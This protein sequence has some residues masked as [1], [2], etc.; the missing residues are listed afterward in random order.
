[1]ERIPRLHF[2]AMLHVFLSTSS[3]I[4]LVDDRVTSSS[5]KKVKI[6]ISMVFVAMEVFLYTPEMGKRTSDLVPV[7]LD[8]PYD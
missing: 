6:L 7:P 2:I 3:S 4:Q 5:I 8:A 1:M